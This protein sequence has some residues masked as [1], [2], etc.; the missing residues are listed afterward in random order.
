VR[1]QHEDALP[2]IMMHGWPGSAIESLETVGPLTDPTAHGDEVLNW[3]GCT[4][5]Q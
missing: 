1:S 2:L 4:E 5:R 3:S